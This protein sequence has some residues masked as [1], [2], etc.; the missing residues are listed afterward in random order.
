[1]TVKQISDMFIGKGNTINFRSLEGGNI[2]KSFLIDSRSGKKYVLQNVNATV[3]TDP[4]AVMKNILLVTDNLRRKNEATLNFVT[5]CGFGGNE[6]GSFVFCD[7]NGEY[8]RC[9]EY[10]G[11]S[12]CLHAAES[13]V[14]SFNTGL[15]YGL[16]LK[17]NSDLAANELNITIENFHDLPLRIEALNAA[18]GG[19]ENK[20][21]D[22]YAEK[23]FFLLIDSLEFV[24]KNLR[25]DLPDRITH[26][27]TKIEN[28]LFDEKT[29]EVIAVADLDTV[30][31][32]KITDD[33]GD[34][35]RSVAA[36]AG[37]NEEDLSKIRFVPEKCDRFIDGF[38]RGVKNMLTEN[39][40]LA[41]QYAPAYVTAELA[42]R[43]LTD[44][45]KGNVYF[46]IEYPEHN[47]MRAANQTILLTSIL[48]NQK[49][50]ADAVNRF[51]Y[52]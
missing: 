41:L 37:E 47:L 48:D 46:K 28:V 39:E 49:K 21:A 15:A 36:S 43:F 30:M 10:V 38:A 14:D 25:D 26:N 3:F 33:F 51:F 34:C 6:C 50:V 31:P 23:V 1:M 29:G 44:Y 11:N 45:F 32:G 17:N 42:C 5:K 40:I 18:Y 12:K 2:N 20:H 9:M 52:R 13:E 8:W 4:L 7:E 24:K 19:Y 27:D 22:V 35:L 16:F